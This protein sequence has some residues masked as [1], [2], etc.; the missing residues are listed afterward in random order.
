MLEDL[1]DVVKLRFNV[2][3]AA[4][5]DKDDEKDE[6]AENKVEIPK[7]LAFKCPRCLNMIMTDEL[8]K[9]LKVCPECGYH[10]RISSEERL[11]LTVDKGS[12]IE[13]DKDMVS[14][15]LSAF[16]DM[17]RSR[18]SFAKKQVCVTLLSRANVRYAVSAALSVLWTLAI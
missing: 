11:N 8:V 12:F 7:D 4:E 3:T 15:N 14:R 5:N 16:R 18:T 2:N 6:K 17:T 1:L 10:S 9:N 13:F